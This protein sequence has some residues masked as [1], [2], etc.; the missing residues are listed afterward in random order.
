MEG[1]SGK[2][3]FSVPKIWFLDWPGTSLHLDS[4]PLA[5]YVRLLLFFY[6]P[7]FLSPPPFATP[8]PFSLLCMLLLSPFAL[9]LIA[10]TTSWL[11]ASAFFSKLIYRFNT[12]PSKIPFGF[13][14]KINKTIPK[15]SYGNAR[16]PE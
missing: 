5:P 8:L 11:R 9:R 10:G 12:I 1:V 4:F 15:K 14:V 13:F 16:D 6:S 2:E 3:E 7:F